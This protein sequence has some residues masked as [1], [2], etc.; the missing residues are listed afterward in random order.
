MQKPVPPGDAGAAG[1]RLHRR[2]EAARGR[3]HAPH[4]GDPR[5]VSTPNR[6]LAWAVLSSTARGRRA[7]RWSTT[8]PATSRPSS[9]S[10]CSTIRNSRNAEVPDHIT[11]RVRVRGGRRS[12]YVDAS[13]ACRAFPLLQ[14][15]ACGGKVSGRSFGAD[16][17]PAIFIAL[18]QTAARR[19]LRVVS[20]KARSLGVSDA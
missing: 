7:A 3:A 5:T 1:R 17:G 6:S 18:F 11:R 9:S 4:R 14:R 19:T 13:R 10:C 12:E 2:Q 8:F 20:M 16:R 15:L